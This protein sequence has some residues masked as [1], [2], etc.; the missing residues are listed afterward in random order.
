MLDKKGSKNTSKLKTL[1]TALLFFLIVV[2]PVFAHGESDAQPKNSKLIITV[3]TEEN[4]SPVAGARVIISGANDIDR[5]AK[6]DS[7]GNATIMKLPREELTVQVVATGFETAGKKVI[8]SLEVETMTVSIRKNL[9]LSDS[10]S[11]NSEPQ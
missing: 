6:T 5:S 9:A 2:A 8:L 10:P 11:D 3:I 4:E 1:A 7:D